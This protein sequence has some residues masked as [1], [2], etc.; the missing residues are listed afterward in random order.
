MTPSCPRC[1]GPLRRSFALT[2]PSVRLDPRINAVRSDLADV[3]LAEF[4]FAPHY[5]APM[6]LIVRHEAMLRDASGGDAAAIVTLEPGEVFEVLELGKDC[7]WGVSP[8][9]GLVGYV[10]T[11]A[12]A[13]ATE[14]R[15]Q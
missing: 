14:D 13:V 7:A 4:V 8:G 9:R 2:G 10:G 5:A 6:P 15:P 12:L 11:S 1:A 3:R